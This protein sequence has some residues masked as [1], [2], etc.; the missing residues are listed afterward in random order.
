M[1][2][3]IFLIIVWALSGA[4]PAAWLAT[5]RGRDSLRWGL[6]G[7]LYGPFAVILCGFSPVKPKVSS[8]YCP[9]CFLD[10]DPRASRCHHCGEGLVPSQ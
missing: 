3:L 2:G 7:L 5:E 1:T 8:V 6:V 10:V 9:T 4:I